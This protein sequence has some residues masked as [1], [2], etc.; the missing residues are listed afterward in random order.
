M[1]RFGRQRPTVDIWRLFIAVEIPHLRGLPV[2]L[3]TFGGQLSCVDTAGWPGSL[4]MVWEVVG[5]SEGGVP[6]WFG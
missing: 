4:L 6:G 2:A 1:S 5:C 3:W